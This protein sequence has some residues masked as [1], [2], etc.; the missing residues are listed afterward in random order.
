MSNVCYTLPATDSQPAIRYSPPV[1]DAG[2]RI[3]TVQRVLGKED[4][5]HVVDPIECN[6]GEV[7]EPDDWNRDT[8]QM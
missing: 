4:Q 1:E 3:A 8:D 7:T 6:D 5:S 2:R